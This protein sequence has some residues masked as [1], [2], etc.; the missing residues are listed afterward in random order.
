MFTINSVLRPKTL[1]TYFT[2]YMY[3]IA[4]EFSYFNLVDMERY[5]IKYEYK[6]KFAFHVFLLFDL[7]CSH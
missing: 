4:I 3:Y 5:M 6:Y 1:I 2:G 7:N